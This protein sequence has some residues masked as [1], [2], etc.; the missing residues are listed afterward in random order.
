VSGLRISIP[1]NTGDEETSL[2]QPASHPASH[3][4]RPE[5]DVVRFL[6]FLL[7]FVHHT[8]PS[9]KDPRI[10][11][12][13]KGFAPALDSITDACG[14]GLSLFFTLSAFLIC[15]LLLRER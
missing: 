14:Y 15:E 3:Y 4:Y 7:V 9:G 6:A 10:I 1:K 12:L 13:L 11:H 8:L 5:L 2:M